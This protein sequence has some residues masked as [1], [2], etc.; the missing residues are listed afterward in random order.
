MD[1]SHIKHKCLFQRVTYAGF[2]ELLLRLLFLKNNQP[3]DKPYAKEAYL[4]VVYFA[5]LHPIV[6]INLIF[7]WYFPSFS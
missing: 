7:F 1:I 6:V 5:L 4:R 3:K 2:S